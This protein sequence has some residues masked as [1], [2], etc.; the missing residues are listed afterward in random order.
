MSKTLSANNGNQDGQVL[1]VHSVDC[2]VFTVP[3]I[4]E[5]VKFYTDF[6]MDVRREGS[7]VELFTFGHPHC[8]MRV[9]ENKQPKALQYLT[10]GTV[11]YTHLTLPTKRIV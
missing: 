1:A 7:V 5:A 8:W 2:V 4:E 9:V 3:D 11:S 10:F 6:G